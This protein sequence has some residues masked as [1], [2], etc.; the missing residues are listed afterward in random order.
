MNERHKKR[1]EF[2]RREYRVAYARDN[3]GGEAI[4]IVERPEDEKGRS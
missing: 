4:V 3:K 1:I 2:D